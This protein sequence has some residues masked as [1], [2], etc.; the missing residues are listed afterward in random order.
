MGDSGAVDWCSAQLLELSKPP[1]FAQH[2]ADSLLECSFALEEVGRTGK[3]NRLRRRAHAIAVHHGY[4]DIAY[5][6]EHST[7]R[8]K[9]RTP[10]R[11]PKTTRAIV[12]EVSALEVENQTLMEIH[13]G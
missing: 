7:P 6:A 1:S 10:R 5:L 8:G 13:A 3:A 12:S 9:P 11:I 2:V 4:H